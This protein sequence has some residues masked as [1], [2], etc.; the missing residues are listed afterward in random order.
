MNEADRTAIIHA[1]ELL[2]KLYR[3][4]LPGEIWLLL[5]MVF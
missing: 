1:L 3:G 2:F 5:K 4:K